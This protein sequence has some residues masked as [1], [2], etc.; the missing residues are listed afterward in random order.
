MPLPH[1]I[2]KETDAILWQR[3]GRILY[4]QSEH[5]R[6]SDSH[7]QF[8]EQLEPLWSPKF[9][10]SHGGFKTARILRDIASLVDRPE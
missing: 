3:V 1:L 4:R 6:D 5:F 9:M 2:L 10:A 7:R 8:A